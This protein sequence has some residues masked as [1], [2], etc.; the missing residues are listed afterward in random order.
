MF[1]P[2]RQLSQILL[3]SSAV[4]VIVSACA[5]ERVSLVSTP[6]SSSMQQSQAPTQKRSPSQLEAAPIVHGLQLIYTIAN[7]SIDGSGAILRIR[8]TLTNVGSVPRHLA[9]SRV[10]ERDRKGAGLLEVSARFATDPQEEICG[11]D[12]AF[13]NWHY[14]PL[15][16]TLNPNESHTEE[17]VVSPQGVKAVRMDGTGR[18]GVICLSLTTTYKLRLTVMPQDLDDGRRVSRGRDLYYP[19]T[20][21]P[22][23]LFLVQL[24]Q[25]PTAPN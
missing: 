10:E 7:A 4:L 25:L 24:N 23:P 14:T 5:S 12:Q 16:L 15:N 13:E 8:A 1:Q 6:A 22:G 18:D 2:A 17:W 11:M 21:I 3:L 19:T 9:N 20:S